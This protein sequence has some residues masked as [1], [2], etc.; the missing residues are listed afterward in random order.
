MS[1]FLFRFIFSFACLLPLSEASHAQLLPQPAQQGFTVSEIFLEN[2]QRVSSTTIF[3]IVRVNIGDQITQADMGTIIRDLMATGFF[4][5]IQVRQGPNDELIISVDERPSISSIE[6]EGNDSIP[7]EILQEN[8]NSIGLAVGELFNPSVLEAMQIAMENQYVAQ[9]LYGASVDVEIE[10]Q[11]RN[12]VAVQINVNEGDASKIVHINIVGNEAF[13]DEELLDLFELK[14]SHF[15]SFISSD[16][17]YSREQITG[18][19]ERLESFYRDQGYVN[20]AITLPVVS[21]SPDRSEIY[22]TINISEGEIYRINDVSLA[23]DLVGSE[24]LLRQ[25]MSFIR[26]GQVFSQIL[27]TQVSEAMTN[28]L[29][30]RGYFFA[31][32]NGVPIIDEDNGTVDVTFFVVPGNRTYVNRISFTGNTVTVDEVLRQEM[33]QMEGAPASASAIE[34]SKVRL[35]RLGYFSSVDYETTEVGGV[36][37][38]VDV[39]FTVEEQLSGAIN[40]SVGYA[41]VMG[42]TLSANLEESNFL[43][44]GNRVGIGVNTNRFSTNYNFNY[45]DPYYTI[46]GVSRGFSLNYTK[47]DYAQLNLASYSTNQFGLSVNFGYPINENQALNFS[48]GYTNTEIETGF[49]PVQEIEG[50]PRVNPLITSYIVSPAR[51]QEYTNPDTG[52]VYP[53]QDAVIAPLSSLPDSAFTSYEEGF[54]DREGSKFNDVTLTFNWTRNNLLQPGLFATGGSSQNF[55]LEF[56]LPGSDLSFYRMRFFAE[57]YKS[58]NDFFS[59]VPPD[60]VLHFEATLGYGDAYGS[61]KQLPFY[62][63]FYAGGLRSIRGFETNTLGPRSTPGQIYTLEPVGLLRDIDGNPILS[64]SGIASYDASSERAYLLRQVVDANGNPVVDARGQPVY[65]NELNTQRIQ[66]TTRAQPFGG[67]IQT[68]GS[69]ELFFPLG[70]VEDRSRL[71]SSFFIDA[72]NVFSSYCTD[73]QIANNNCSNFSLSE[74]RYSAGIS[75]SWFSGLLGVMTFSLAKPFN[76]SI[77]DEREIFQFDVGSTF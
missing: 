20:F 8:L 63:N 7:D 11:A 5:D 54:V 53:V 56:A 66:F 35:E 70:F 57:K 34:Q 71:R 15:T 72:G 3:S 29:S 55:S 28:T 59:F 17:R 77:I 27:I 76:N 10:E 19:L 25:I 23:G 39:N 26:P 45:F 50:S 24:D 4:D 33:R 48:L 51:L 38:Q 13:S 68:I 69:A 65:E 30:N 74:F 52:T 32:V 46:D 67:N 49:G 62:R 36:T 44:T 22:I 43:G 58:L 21:L 47:S 9:G 40:F 75:V 61:S 2:L 60:W 1:R 37:D 41:Q 12:R 6:I 14:E 73:R 42:L 64:S 18:D 31:E 16:D